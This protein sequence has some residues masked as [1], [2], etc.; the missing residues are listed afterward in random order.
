MGDKFL[1]ETWVIVACLTGSGPDWYASD[2]LQPPR[3]LLQMAVL[4]SAT[5]A[6]IGC[7]TQPATSANKET[8][9][10]PRSAGPCDSKILVSFAQGTPQP[11]DRS[12]IQDLERSA[13]VRLLF[14]SQISGNLDLFAL[15]VPE[16][17]PECGNALQRLRHDS[18]IRSAD[19]DSRR[20]PH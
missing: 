12:L 3:F 2:T 14:V 1:A 15:S 4:L 8:S 18:R 5:A 7:A 16:V 9:D 10:V 17:D 19:L 11:P 20:Q 6:V 13:G